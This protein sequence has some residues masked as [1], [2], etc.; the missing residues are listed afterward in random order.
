[1]FAVR[2]SSTPPSVT[3]PTVSMPSSTRSTRSC[4]DA[5]ARVFVRGPVVGGLLAGFAVMYVT[6]MLVG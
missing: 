2:P 3:V 4:A 1:M 5:A 6:G